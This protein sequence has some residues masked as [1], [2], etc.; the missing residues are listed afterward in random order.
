M[1]NRIWYEPLEEDSIKQ[2]IEV[3]IL[4]NIRKLYA[5]I[6]LLSL[7]VVAWESCLAGIALENV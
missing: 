5:H 7:S 2:P 1:K 3:L 4:K 6:W